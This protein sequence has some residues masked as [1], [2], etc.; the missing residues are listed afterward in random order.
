MTANPT[1]TEQSFARTRPLDDL[2]IA[3]TRPAFS[4]LEGIRVLDVTSSIA[5]P[6]G[7]MLLADLGA[8]VVKVEPAGRGDDA[9]AWGPPFLHGEA[10]WFL[11]VNRNKRSIALDL[12]KPGNR[13]LLVRLACAADVVITT[14]RGRQLAK[15]GIDYPALKV[16]RPDL[17]YCA[18]TGYGLTGPNSSLPGYDL[19]AEG[20]SGIMDLTG[21]PET[22]PQ[23]VGAP[24]ADMLAGMDAAFAIVAA[25]FDRER[26]GKGHHIDVSL[27]ESM[28]RLLTPKFTSYLGSGELQRRTGGRDS[29]IAVYQAFDTA[30][31]PITLALGN[32]KIFTRF[33]DAIGRNDMSIDPR[34]TGNASRRQHRAHLVAEIQAILREQPSAHWLRIFDDADIPAGPINHLEAVVADPHLIEREMFYRYKYDGHEIPQV[35]TG[36]HLDSAANTPRRPPPRLGAHTES[37]PLEWLAPH[38]NTESPQRII[39]DQPAH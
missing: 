12:S 20:V 30:D 25:L 3:P 6:Y 32:D 35:N 1:P 26:N 14:L 10:L 33:C 2:P 8:D 34:F 38:V 16:R 29:V 22:G 23:K 21:E 5:G 27:V 15:L 9:R 13:E 19:I 17:I 28:I 7:T 18:I 31:D 39:D 24:A 11:A 37:A 4:L 36:W